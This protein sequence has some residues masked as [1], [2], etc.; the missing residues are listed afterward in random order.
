[1]IG[2]MNVVRRTTAGISFNGPAPQLWR[3]LWLGSDALFR[4]D[5]STVE[6]YA[7]FYGICHECLV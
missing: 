7:Q 2:N 3:W 1:M 6:A 4:K 5:L